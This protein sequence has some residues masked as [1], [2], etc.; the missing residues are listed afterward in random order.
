MALNSGVNLDPE[1]KSIVGEIAPGQLAAVAA[2]LEHWAKQLRDLDSLDFHQR[3]GP[4]LPTIL[5][6][7]I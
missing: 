4:P 2:Q 6:L 3:D 7:S 1:L 5:W